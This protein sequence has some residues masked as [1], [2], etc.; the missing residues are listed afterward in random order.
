MRTQLI[1]AK[2]EPL[3]EH[4]FTA[5]TAPKRTLRDWETDMFW[6][7]GDAKDPTAWG[8][9]MWTNDGILVALVQIKG[10][11]TLY[12]SPAT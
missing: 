9:I 11:L 4:R 3:E 8:C 2:V 7:R 12:S 5:G 10:I 6:R 1:P